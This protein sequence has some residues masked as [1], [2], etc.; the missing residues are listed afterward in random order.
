MIAPS[1]MAERLVLDPPAA[2]AFGVVS[3]V[4]NFTTL[5][6]VIPAAKEIAASDIELLA[7]IFSALVLV[8]LAA[9]SGGFRQYLLSR[10]EPV[11][12][13]L[14][15]GLDHRIDDVVHLLDGSNDLVERLAGCV[16]EVGA[17][18]HFFAAVFDEFL[19]PFTFGL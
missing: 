11:D 13:V 9:I 5:A 6:L 14:V 10:H 12:D 15:T 18:F 19:D 4:T 17:F 1:P 16:D 2:L 7:R 3:M 8:V